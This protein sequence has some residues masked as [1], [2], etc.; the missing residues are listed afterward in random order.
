MKLSDRDRDRSS[1]AEPIETF[2]GML[3][4]EIDHTLLAYNTRAGEEPV[5]AGRGKI[6]YYRNPMGLPDFSPEPKKDSMGMDYIPVYE[7]EQADDGSIKL[8]P[9]SGQFFAS[10]NSLVKPRAPAGVR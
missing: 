3:A 5:Q 2:L 9:G 6:L 7:N 8:S 10:L 1:I 4:K